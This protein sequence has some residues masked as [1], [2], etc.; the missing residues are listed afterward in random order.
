MIV[1]D[2]M[3]LA[4]QCAPDVSPATMT[5]IVR[6]ES[7]F[8]PYAI[9]VVRG[10]LLHQ[11]SSIEEAIATVRALDAGHWNYSVGLAQVNRSNWPRLGLNVQDAFD[12]C[13]NLAAGGAILQN[14]FQLAR[15]SQTDVQ[16][17]L[18][19]GLSCYASGSL[20]T[21]YRTGYVQRVVNNAT[22]NVAVRPL[23]TVPAIA[24]S[25][26]PIPVVPT[27][28]D[29]LPAQPFRQ[30]VEHGQPGTNLFDP[31]RGERDERP[32]NSAVVF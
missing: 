6:T 25:V 1:P 24:P 5:A 32:D 2:L 17:A 18:R 4:Q 21:G 10:R 31:Q 8:N 3:T 29:G 15:A 16:R 19:Q 13:R 26:S 12:P 30:T 27:D 11:P 9:G 20:V 22:A 7:A 28:S 23:P 14:C